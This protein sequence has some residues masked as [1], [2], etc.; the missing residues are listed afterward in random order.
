MLASVLETVA[1]CLF[2]LIGSWWKWPFRMD[3]RFPSE[4]EKVVMRV[5]GSKEKELVR[6]QRGPQAVA[7]PPRPS[8]DR[9]AR[10]E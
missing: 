2:L 5:R 8:G 7:T 10:R 4:S 1:H 6:A 3:T 9:G